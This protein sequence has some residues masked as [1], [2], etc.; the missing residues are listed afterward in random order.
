MKIDG[1]P[2]RTI[3]PTADGKAVEVIDQTLLPHRLV[4]ARLASGHPINRL[5]ELLP[6]NWQRQPAKMAA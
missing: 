5:A 2:F 6:W 4:I 3:W 1:K